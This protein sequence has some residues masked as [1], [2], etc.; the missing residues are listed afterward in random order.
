MAGTSPPITGRLYVT[1]IPSDFVEDDLRALFGAHGLLIGCDI[2]RLPSGMSRNCGFVNFDTV[3]EATAAMAHLNGYVRGPG[4]RP[5][6]VE[7]PESQEQKDLRKSRGGGGRVGYSSPPPPFFG[8]PRGGGGGTTAAL[9]A[10]SGMGGQA[11]PPMYMGGPGVGG[12]PPHPGP[13]LLH[14]GSVYS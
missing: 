11:G 14:D 1:G 7:W 13:Y 4:D 10:A 2:L 5:M 6:H 3:D 9:L 12:G 8:G